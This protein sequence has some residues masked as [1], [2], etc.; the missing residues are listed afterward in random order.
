MIDEV[1]DGTQAVLRSD[2]P[3]DRDGAEVPLRPLGPG[4][5]T[6]GH[7]VYLRLRQAILDLDY[8][9]GA[10][11]RKPEICARLGVSR[12]PVAD[13]VARLAVEGLVEVHPQAGTYVARLSM[14][15]I[16]EGAFL[17]E[18]IELAAI[19]RVAPGI[20]DAQL[21][22]LDANL[23]LQARLLEQGDRAAFQACDAAFHELILSF[24]GFANLARVSQTA[25]LQV[26]RA[27]RLLL[28]VA[29]RPE[30]T[31]AEH[32]AILTALRARDAMAARAAVHHHLGQLLR[33]LEPL[34]RSRPD[35]F[36]T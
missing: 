18:A 16:R 32:R 9:P 20:T 24:T 12:S 8:G 33:L 1:H 22:A 36:E 7:K 27:R 35:L 23:A 25:W 30:A 19:E 29:G 3:F 10:I 13:A 2:L 26:D 6:L 17:R 34:E 11:L 4:D 14:A 31:L 21:G 15:E 28:P 5:G